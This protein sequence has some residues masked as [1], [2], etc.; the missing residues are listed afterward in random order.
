MNHVHMLCVKLWAR[1]NDAWRI[2]VYLARI[3]PAQEEMFQQ[4]IFWM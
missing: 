2:A 4:K 3:A 1:S